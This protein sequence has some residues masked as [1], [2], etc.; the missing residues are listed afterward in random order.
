MEETT[1]EGLA[2]VVDAL[3]W[4][5]VTYIPMMLEEL[6]WEGLAVA[7]VPTFGLRAWA[8]SLA[9][10]FADVLGRAFVASDIELYA[11]WCCRQPDPGEAARALACIA[12]LAP[13][14]AAELALVE[15]VGG[16]D[17]LLAPYTS[18]FTPLALQ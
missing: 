2:A 3:V 13:T 11:A 15:H 18:S 7:R 17:A 5:D 9:T 16:R 14:G 4:S 6:P 8:L 12:L 1:K 10:V